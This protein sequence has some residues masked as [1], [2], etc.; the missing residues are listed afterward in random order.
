LIENSALSKIVIEESNAYGNTPLFSAIRAGNVEVVRL[1][2]EKGFDINTTNHLGSTVLHLCCFLA[3]PTEM[4]QNESE[5]ISLEDKKTSNVLV[6][7]PHVQIAA[8]LL[9]DERFKMINAKDENG[10]T[11]LHVAAQRGCNE[12]V[13]LLI[14]SGSDP[15]ICTTVDSKGRGGRT[16]LG[17][18]TFGSQEKTIQLILEIEKTKAD[19]SY[20]PG[21]KLASDLKS[22]YSI[23]NPIVGAGIIG[24][25]R[26]S[27]C[28]EGIGRN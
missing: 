10:H 22:G 27:D 26:K 16:A 19:K 12:M 14:D 15:S 5:S 7:Q 21:G 24:V 17:M 1:L 25:R 6:V 4:K 13:K 8:I 2:I 23:S 9:S 20:V 18:A 28:F 11:P 3:V